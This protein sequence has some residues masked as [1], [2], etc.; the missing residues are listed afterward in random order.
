ICGGKDKGSDFTDFAR[1]VRDKCSFAVVIGV[2]RDKILAAFAKEGFE[3]C[4]PAGTLKEAVAAA[5]RR[6][7]PGD[8]VALT[9]GCASFDMF[10]SF[11]DRG[12]QF[13]ACVKELAENE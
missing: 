2:D 10:S 4:C 6:A 13:A 5:A 11:E 7:R 9:P 12:E 8:T 1:A 3:A